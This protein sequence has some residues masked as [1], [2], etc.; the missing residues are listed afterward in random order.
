MG[1]CKALGSFLCIPLTKKVKVIYDY[2]VGL[3]VTVIANVI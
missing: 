1:F 2:C 3:F